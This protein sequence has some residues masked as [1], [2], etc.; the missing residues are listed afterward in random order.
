MKSLTLISLFF[1][2]WLAATN[3]QTGAKGSTKVL[4]T[5]EEK[6]THIS[7]RLSIKYGLDEDQ[8]SQLYASTLT[9][10]Q[11]TKEIQAANQNVDRKEHAISLQAVKEQYDADLKR[12]MTVE[13]YDRLKKDLEARKQN[14]GK[15]SSSKSQKIKPSPN[16]NAILDELDD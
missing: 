16:A 6:A 7:N 11:K 5:P 8:K 1:I 13:Q 3:A 14:K 9:K 15:Q 4:K 10:I 12:I 2:G